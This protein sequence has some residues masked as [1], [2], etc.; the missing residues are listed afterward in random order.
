MIKDLG[1]Y[2]VAEKLEVPYTTVH[3]WVLK[4]KIPPW[5][6]V[7][8]AEAIRAILIEDAVDLQAAE[9]GQRG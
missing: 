3:S 2:R 6:E 9:A 4:G 7:A 5:R 1:T 8:V